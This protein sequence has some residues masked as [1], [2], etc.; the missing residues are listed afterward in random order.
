MAKVKYKEV[1]EKLEKLAAPSPGNT[2]QR[3][4]IY[5]SVNMAEYYNIDID[6]LIP[7]S[8]QARRIFDDQE[9]QALADS[10]IQHGVRQPLTII[11]SPSNNNLYEIVSG[12][13][14]LRAARLA[15]LAQVPCIILSDYTAAEEIALIENLQRKDLHPIEIGN[16]LKDLLTTRKNLTQQDICKKLGLR[17]QYV[18]EMI[19]FAEL[20]EEVKDEVLK[21][22]ISS[23]DLLRKLLKSNSPLE[24]LKKDHTVDQFKG[25]SKRSSNK[26]ILRIVFKDG[27][28]NVQANGIKLL[29]IREKED[30]KNIL[31]SLV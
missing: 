17:K 6:K 31:N 29:S 8:K 14:R 12:E 27:S 28:F 16:A 19:Q 9:L 3:G 18:S 2:T 4:S 21:N 10:I 24:L 1:S 7:F 26:S 11:K 20:P 30:L 5:S 22:N 13:R 23:R 25:L 15:G